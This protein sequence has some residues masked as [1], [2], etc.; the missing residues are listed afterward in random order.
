M[1]DIT[2]Y[3]LNYYKNGDKKWFEKIYN[4]FMPKIYNFFYFKTMDKQISEDLS[5]EVFIK[6][7]KNLRNKKF[8]SRSF[9][10]WIYKIAKNQFIDYYRKIKKDTENTFLIDWQTEE[11]KQDYILL[12]NDFFKKNSVL[13]KKEFGFENH[14]LIESLGK[15][16]EL[17]KNV[18]V[19]MFV[20]DFDYETISKILGKSKSTIRG[21]IFRA[22]NTLKSE[23]ENG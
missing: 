18:I 15:L 11:N 14:K 3:L 6:V 9:N 4:C 7:Y 2:G 20:L 12:E 13:I 22:I 8:N 21:I 23:F 1:D 19:L 16:T 5:S 17:Q 10:V